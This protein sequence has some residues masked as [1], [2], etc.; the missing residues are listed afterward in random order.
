MTLGKRR[1][2]AI[3][4]ALAGLLILGPNSTATAR[5]RYDR[6]VD[7]INNSNLVIYAFHAT[8]AGVKHWGRDLLGQ[9]VI[10]PGQGYRI[11][12]DDGTGYCMFDFKAVLD[13]GRAIERYR[14]DVCTAA[15]WTI[16]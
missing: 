10:K 4:L 3:G 7:I 12:F 14:V 15:T 9:N 5:D 2:F 13:N 11:N 6:H 1:L 16:Q 8:N